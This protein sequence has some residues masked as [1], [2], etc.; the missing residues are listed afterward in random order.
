M[1]A[2]FDPKDDR[3]GYAIENTHFLRVPRQHLSTFGTTNVR[4]FLLTTPAY[5]GVVQSSED[6]VIREGARNLGTAEGGHSGVHA[7][8]A[9]IRGRG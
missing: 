7:Q 3:I 9:G 4:Y 1:D 2:D 8:P 5:S 6:T